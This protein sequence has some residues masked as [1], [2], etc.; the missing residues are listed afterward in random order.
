MESTHLVRADET[1]IADALTALTG[2]ESIE[3][4]KPVLPLWS[5]YYRQGYDEG[6][7]RAVADLVR[8]VMDLSEQYIKEAAS[9]DCAQEIR[10]ILL[11]F[12]EFLERRIDRMSP[13]G[14]GYVHG[15]LGI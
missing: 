2:Q 15:G 5:L 6:Y 13:E 3:D 10:C 4:Q 14:D 11:P 8:S 9:P 12:E 7:R 1:R